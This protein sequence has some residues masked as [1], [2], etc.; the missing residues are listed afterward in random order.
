VL[1][2]LLAT[3]AAAGQPREE[4][5]AFGLRFVVDDALASSPAR[6]EATGTALA[7][8]VSEL[9]GYYQDSQVVLRAEVVGV[10]FAHLASR[11]ATAVLRDMEQER[12][13][14]GNMFACADEIGADY[15]IAVSDGLTVHGRRGCGRGFAVN[16]TPAQIASSRRA[17]AV[18][19]LACG[20][21]TL[22][23]E[24]GHLMG[25]NHGALVDQCQPGRGHRTAIAPYANGFAAGHC[26]GRPDP[27]K[28]GTIMVGGWM[29]TIAGEQRN[30]PLFSNPRLRDARCGAS[31]VCGD[32][33]IGDEARAL[34][35]NAWTYAAHEEP[36]GRRPASGICR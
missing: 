5:V 7:R 21:Q 8:M 10:S 35:E 15:T 31:G 30:L 25:L 33:E 32:P 14:F 36:D 1:T 28:F 34:N 29:R 12:N 9:N 3:A 4:T 11:E 6:R 13:G 17:F 22:A 20:S 19:D 2:A 24:L 18:I 27:G 16:S 26:D 23:H